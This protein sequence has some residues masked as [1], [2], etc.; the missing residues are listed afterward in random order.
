M[1]GGKDTMLSVSKREFERAYRKHK[2]AFATLGSNVTYSRHLLLFYAV[3]CALKA[4]LLEYYQLD[5]YN[6]LP[7]EAQIVHRLNAGL[8]LLRLPIRIPV[9]RA[10]DLQQSP[11]ADHQLHEAWRYG[12]SLDKESEAVSALTTALRLLEGRM[13]GG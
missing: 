13:N 2:D 1:A 11:V 12:K 6:K 9:A 7:Q 10:N 8:D 5:A 4:Q 3:E